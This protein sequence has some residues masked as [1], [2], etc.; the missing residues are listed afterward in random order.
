[1]TDVEALQTA[2]R[3]HWFSEPDAK[4]QRYVGRWR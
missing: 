3:S 1:M 2:I 4:V